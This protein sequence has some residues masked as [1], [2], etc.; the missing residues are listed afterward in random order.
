MPWRFRRHEHLYITSNIELICNYSSSVTSKWTIY[1]HSDGNRLNYSLNTS[2]KDLFIPSQT[3][4]SGLYKFE[5][6][7]TVT[8]DPSVQ[9]SV[10]VYIDISETTIH[11][12]LI[13]MNTLILQ[14]D[15]QEDLLFDPGQFS[16]D[17]NRVMNKQEVSDR[18][19][20]KISFSI[21]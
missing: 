11:V 18:F 1:N 15:Y 2:E 20:L 6:T 21:Y 19:L 3:L 12:Q 10:S 5:L 4:S 7:I 8:N 17:M 16:L 9:S 13:E 14:H